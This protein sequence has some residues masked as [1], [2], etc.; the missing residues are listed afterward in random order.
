MRRREAGRGAA[1]AGRIAIR[2]SGGIGAPPGTT[3]SP[4][5]ELAEGLGRRIERGRRK[6][7]PGV[8]RKRRREE[9]HALK[10]VRDAQHA[11]KQRE[12]R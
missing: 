10:P 9:K 4:C 1:P 7:G 8:Q 2:H 5:Q 11:L 6:A 3:T 12:A